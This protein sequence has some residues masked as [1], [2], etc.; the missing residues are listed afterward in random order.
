MGIGKKDARGSQAIKI[1]GSSLRVSTQ[2]ADPV[3]EIVHGDEQDVRSCPLDHRG[4]PQQTD[5]IKQVFHDAYLT[6]EYVLPLKEN[7]SLT[8][9]WHPKSYRRG[10]FQR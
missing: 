5:D 7:L 10:C 3:I 8:N 2:A 4:H 6:Y 9:S 1:G